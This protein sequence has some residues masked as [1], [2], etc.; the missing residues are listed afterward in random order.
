M[1]C[2]AIGD[3]E[4]VAGHSAGRQADGHGHG[5]GVAQFSV[6]EQLIVVGISGDGHSRRGGSGGVDLVITQ[7]TCCTCITCLVNAC[8]RCC[9]AVG[10]TQFAG[11]DV[12]RETK[13]AVGFGDDRAAVNIAADIQCDGVTDAGF[14]AHAAGNSDEVSKQLSGIERVVS[15]DGVNTDR[16]HRRGCVDKYCARVVCICPTYLFNTLS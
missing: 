10:V 11:S 5:G 15:R 2:G 6:A 16:N 3:G 7:R 12:Y 1:R 8:E 13:C 14:A 4:G 9:D